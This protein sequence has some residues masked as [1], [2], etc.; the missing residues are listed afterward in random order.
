M[1]ANYS[2]AI[3]D[4]CQQQYTVLEHFLEDDQYTNLQNLIS[5][6]YD[7][8]TFRQAGIGRLADKQQNETIRQDQISWLDEHEQEPRVANFVNQLQSLMQQLNK[9]LY[10]GLQSFESHFAIYEPGTF[11]KK[12]RDQFQQDD[13]RRIS[14]VYYLNLAW[15]PAHGGE[16][17]LYDTPV[18]DVIIPPKGNQLVCFVSNLLH[19]VKITHQ[20]RLSI[21]TWFKSGAMPPLALKQTKQL[22]D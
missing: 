18:G 9:E 14:C 13:A 22:I 2:Q 10:L 20:R 11:Y 5:A 12:H 21:T 16:L 19:E 15:Q 8:Q 1:Q 4:L 3:D 6:L 7:Q 17:V